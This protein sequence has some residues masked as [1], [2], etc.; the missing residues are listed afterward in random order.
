MNDVKDILELVK[1]KIERNEEYFTK[2]Q[3][4]YKPH[5]GGQAIANSNNASPNEMPK[6]TLINNNKGPGGGF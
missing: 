3:G 4:A 5:G 2:N 6:L 1:I